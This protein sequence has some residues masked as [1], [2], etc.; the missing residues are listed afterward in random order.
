MSLLIRP[1]LSCHEQLCLC[2][3]HCEDR[4]SG[5]TAVVWTGVSHSTLHMLLTPAVVTGF[6]GL[7]N[8]HWLLP[9]LDLPLSVYK[10][11]SSSLSV[12]LM[13]LY[14]HNPSLS[15]LKHFIVFYCAPL[16]CSCVHVYLCCQGFH[17]SLSLSLSLS[18]VPCRPVLPK[19]NDKAQESFIPEHSWISQ[20]YV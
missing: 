8:T 1:S 6:C 15:L 9:S 11:F 17:H 3:V 20:Y 7:Y 16:L 14:F 5:L 13:V 10:C 4:L 18:L 12:T 2:A 19:C